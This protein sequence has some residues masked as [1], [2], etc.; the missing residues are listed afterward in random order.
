METQKSCSNQPRKPNFSILKNIFYFRMKNTQLSREY[1]VNIHKMHTQQKKTTTN[2]PRPVGKMKSFSCLIHR[3]PS[4]KVYFIK[5]FGFIYIYIYI[6]HS[7]LFAGW[8]WKPYY[9][10]V[11][12]WNCYVDEHK[13]H[14]LKKNASK[15]FAE[16]L[17]SSGHFSLTNINV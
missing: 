3:N 4:G 1:V 9:I 10:A 16:F 15:Y 13:Y 6:A 8:N 12:G 2:H 14:T 5:W 7:E 17:K 11:V